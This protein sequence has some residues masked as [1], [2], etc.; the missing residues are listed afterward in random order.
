MRN[1]I[2][3]LVTFGFLFI[4]TMVVGQIQYGTIEYEV[5]VN[6]EKRF[7]STSSGPNFGGGR[8]G[9]MQSASNRYLTEKATLY[10]NDTVSVFVTEA[11]ES[12]MDQN[13]TYLTNTKVSLESGYAETQINLLG[14]L[15]LVKDELPIYVWKFTSKERQIAGKMAKQAITQI[16]ENTTIYAWFDTDVYPSVGPEGFR[17]LPGAILGLAYE[18]GSVTYFA[19]SIQTNYVNAFEQFPNERIRNTYDR[20]T[21][22]EE[23]EG[24]YKEDHRLYYLVRDLL[25]FM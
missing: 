15:F 8:G 14:E 22:K 20:T 19:K 11:Q 18:D 12:M 25:N 6:L 7:P 24:K 2:E 9:R 16:D 10:F 13:R 3:I 5:T 23:F 17:G 1:K 21:F 4:A